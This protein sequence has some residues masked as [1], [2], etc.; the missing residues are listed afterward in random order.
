MQVSLYSIILPRLVAKELEGHKLIVLVV[1]A[2]EDLSKVTLPQ[3][4]KHL[5]AITN[6]IT[7]DLYKIG[8]C[9]FIFKYY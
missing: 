9:L 3:N 5:V 7:C 6:V 8:Y 1:K 2:L 4:T